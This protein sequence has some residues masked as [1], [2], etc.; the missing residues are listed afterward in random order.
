[1]RK[2]IMSL[3]DFSRKE[4]TGIY[5]LIFISTCVWV[6]PLFFS[7]DE[8][9]LDSLKITAL[10]MDAKKKILLYRR[11]SSI[12]S[13]NKSTFKNNT[14]SK[15]EDIPINLFYFNPNEIGKEEWMKLGLSE[16]NAITILKYI[17]KGGKF[18]NKEDLKKIY[19][20][21]EM[22]IEK[23]MPYAVFKTDQPIINKNEFNSAKLKPIKK[24]DINEADSSVLID[25]PGIGEKLSARII[26]YRDRL[27]GFHSAEQLSEVFGI[28]DSAFLLINERI[29]IAD[30]SSVKKISINTVDYKELTKHPY[31]SFLMAK[32]ILAYRKAHGKFSGADD[33]KMIEGIDADKVRKIIPYL[34]F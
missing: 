2:T 30:A 14:T 1:M 27:G 15:A 8:I 29:Y 6:I 20:V 28:S 23:I 26:K 18:R 25:L 9:N 22:V 32:L 4:R 17:T 16:K 12:R 5:L 10:E 31:M 33:L 19:G 11:D 34:S 3:L 13:F 21:P 24:V 7:K